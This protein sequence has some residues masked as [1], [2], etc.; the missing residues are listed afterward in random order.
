MRQNRWILCCAESTTHHDECE[1]CKCRRPR[2]NVKRQDD[3]RA[4]NTVRAG[5]RMSVDA[6]SLHQSV[7]AD[8]L[9][10]DTS[11]TVPEQN[12]KSKRNDT[13]RYG[14]RDEEQIEL[15][16]D[17]REFKHRLKLKPATK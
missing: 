6:L 13:V 10:F 3:E 9:R 4:E 2:A 8:D 16:L 5:P 11:P 17:R 12:A 15:P 14:R 7:L 1:S